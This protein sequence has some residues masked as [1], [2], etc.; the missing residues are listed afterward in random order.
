M[1]AGAG[2][3]FR[4]DFRLA[5]AR[6]KAQTFGM[7]IASRLAALA[8]LA[9]L[10]ACATAGGDLRV[11]SAATSAPA[12]DRSQ[13]GLFLAGQ[14]ALNS[15]HSAEAADYFARAS[16]DAPGSGLLKERAFTAALIA[17]DVSRAAQ[18]APGPDDGSAVSQRLGR[19]TQAVDALASGKGK[20]AYAILSGDP[21][22]VPHRTAAAL[23]KPWAAAAAGDWTAAVVAPDLP[24][25]RF[26]QYFATLD[27]GLLFERAKR[28]DDAEAAFKSLLERDD[29]P[30]I[31]PLAYGA[32]LERRGRQADAVEI[33]DRALKRAPN[34]ASLRAAKARAEAKGAPPP[35]PTLA[36]GAAQAVLA[37]AAQ[38]LA[39][40][41]PEMGLAYLRLVLRLDPSRD[42]AWL[43]V[44]DA[45]REAGDVDAARSAYNRPRA[46][47]SE[48]AAA[49]ARLAWTYQDASDGPGAL[50]IIDEAVK[51]APDSIDAQTAYA[52]LLRA[53]KRY[54]ESAA[55]LDKVV[56]QEGDRAD[57]RLYYARGVSLERAGRWPEAERDLRQALKLQPDQPEVLN[58]LGYSWV[59]R[60][61]RLKEA[62][63]MIEK[64]VEAQ[65]KSGAMT[66][67]LGWAHY[68]LGDYKRAVD[69]L[70]RAVEL[71]ASDPDVNNHLGDASWR[72]G[73]KLEARFQWNRVLTL[74]PEPALRDEV[75]QKLK[76]G[77]GAGKAVAAA[78]AAS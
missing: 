11:R 60:G 52:D 5:G 25:D 27:Q 42:E 29:G 10:A 16:N 15:G 45:M 41:Q 4:S 44:G 66:D 14:A 55:V 56:V 9:P 78:V 8:L 53:N 68:R 37:P 59:D 28:Y 35:Q 67:S 40:K 22:G 49:R 2:R 72:V 26:G 6:M 48:Y 18:L 73:R 46:G 47:S 57:W 61:E 58:Y 13:Y 71:D 39:Q 65:P 33:Y 12:P 50:K 7:S 21:I 1:T 77:L 31:F 20:A 70:E 30:G 75:E 23:L 74:E 51:A 24:G 76:S 64:A 54:A 3:A 32:F 69:L 63:A 62:L 34:D 36:E 43:L 38:L 17:G 19:L